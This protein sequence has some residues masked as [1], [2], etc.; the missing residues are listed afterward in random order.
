[1]AGTQKRVRIFV[2]VVPNCSLTCFTAI[3]IEVHEYSKVYNCDTVYACSVGVYKSNLK[4]MCTSALCVLVH[5]CLKC[6]HIAMF[7]I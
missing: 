5:V 6:K 4:H 1:M 7:Q 2:R 3:C